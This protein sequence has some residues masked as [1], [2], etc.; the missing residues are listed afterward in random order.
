MT[1]QVFEKEYGHL[2]SALPYD[3]C[4]IWTGKDNGKGYG[5]IC[6]EGKVQ[7]VHRLSWEL[8]RGSIPKGYC[9]C[10]KCDVPSC[11]NPDHLFVGTKGDNNRDMQR[12]GRHNGERAGSKLTTAQ[13]LEIRELISEGMAQRPIAK[14]YGVTQKAVSLIN[15]KENW[16]WLKTPALSDKE[17]KT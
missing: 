6:T 4:W 8:Y 13:V 5:Y 9:V 17:D 16:G 12:K 10:H 14:R 1:K 7:Y 2:I 3:G 15:T 11:I